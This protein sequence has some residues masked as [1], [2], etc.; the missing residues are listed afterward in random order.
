MRLSKQKKR[1]KA[2]FF[3]NLRTYEWTKCN[4]L[5]ELQRSWDEKP[6]IR[7]CSMK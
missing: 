1:T 7:S 5:N 2:L 4:I 3:M 6:L